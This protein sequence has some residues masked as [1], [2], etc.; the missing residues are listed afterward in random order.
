M[1]LISQSERR[2]IFYSEVQAKR[3]VTPTQMRLIVGDQMVLLNFAD[4][5]VTAM[6]DFY[7]NQRRVPKA[8]LEVYQQHKQLRMSDFQPVA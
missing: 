2:Q 7:L 3:V 8:A 6:L 1:E 4:V 5:L